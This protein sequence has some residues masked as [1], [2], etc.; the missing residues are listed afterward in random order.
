MGGGPG[1][2]APVGKGR[3]VEKSGELEGRAREGKKKGS[4]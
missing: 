4:C 3:G 1:R 2:P